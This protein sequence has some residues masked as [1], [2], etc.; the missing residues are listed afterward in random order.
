MRISLQAG[1]I[2]AVVFGFGSCTTGTREYDIDRDVLSSIVRQM[3]K[4]QISGYVVLSSTTSVVSP[5]FT[6]NGIDESARYSL[7]ERNMTSFALPPIDSCKSMRLVVGGEISR[8]LEVSTLNMHERWAAF[9]RKFT[10]ASGVMTISLPG[11]SAE[12]DLAVV[13]VAASCGETCGG[14]S[15]WVLRKISGR[16]QVDVVVPGWQS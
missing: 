6:P 8:Y 5:T 15:F 2:L 3:C 13:Q 12:G 7:L 14:G 4:Q 10:D 16:W 9:Y 11:Y 1:S